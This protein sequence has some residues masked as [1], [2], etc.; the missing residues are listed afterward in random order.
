MFEAKNFSF[1]DIKLIYVQII[2][3]NKSKAPKAEENIKL[4]IKVI[5]H[6][7]LHCHSALSKKY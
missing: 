4:K 5:S 7:N 1:I 6:S 2:C 3:N